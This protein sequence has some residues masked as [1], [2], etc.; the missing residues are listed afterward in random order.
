[1]SPGRDLS[2]D[3]REMPGPVLDIPDDD[4]PEPAEAADLRAAAAV[5]SIRWLVVRRLLWLV[6]PGLASAARLVGR[7]A[8]H[9]ARQEA[10]A[11]LALVVTRY[12]RAL[13]AKAKDVHRWK[14][15]ADARELELDAI[16]GLN[17]RLVARVAAE[18]TA[19]RAAEATLTQRAG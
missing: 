12:E 16:T 2:G 6:A 4:T 14:T 3:Y 13:L 7:T 18:T 8:A 15:L 17:V 19:I 9:A 5:V 10:A 11:R 1:M